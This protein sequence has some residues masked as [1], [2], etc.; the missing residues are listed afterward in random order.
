MRI[1]KAQSKR[2]IE[3]GPLEIILNLNFM[4]GID[5]PPGWFSDKI[6]LDDTTKYK[7]VDDDHV[8]VHDTDMY[9]WKKIDS[10]QGDSH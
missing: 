1:I 2:S 3:E 7:F 8:N 4:M 9:Y 6:G 5:N 10:A